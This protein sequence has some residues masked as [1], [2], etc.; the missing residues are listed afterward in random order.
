MKRLLRSSSPS[1]PLR[2]TLE[3]PGD[4]SMSHRAL[5][6]SALSRGLSQVTNLNTGQDCVATA[7][8]LTELG[9]RCTIHETNAEVEVEGCGVG[10]FHEADGV[11][12]AGNSGTTL[13]ILLGVCAGID[14]W[15][16]LTGDAS[17]RTRPMLRV[18]APLRQMGARIDGR[19]HGDRAPLA[20]RGGSLSGVDLE[21]PVASAQLKTA[22]LFAGLAA[23]GRTSVTV[24]GPSRDHTERMLAAA[25]ARL[26]AS[27]GKVVLDP[28]VGPE[29]ARWDVPGD[30]SSAAFLLAAAAL[31]PGSDLTIENVGL[32]PTR[33]GALEVMRRMGAAIEVQVTGERGGEPVGWVRARASYLTASDIEGEEIPS[34]IDELP[35]LAVLAANAE[36]RTVIR[37]AAELRVKESDRI[38]V[39]TEGLRILGVDCEATPDG[40]VIDGP[41]HLA[42]GTVDSR[43]DHRTAMSFAVA[44]LGAAGSVKV[45]GWGCVNT[46]FP[47]FLDL[48]GRAQGGHE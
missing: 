23:E 3:V 40:M 36:G 34:L 14:G 25:G 43:G 31:V 9:A 2:G 10:G 17:L 15:S 35:L 41:A 5:M 19:A 6:I 45:E 20:V 8:L 7:R 46:S 32:N 13:R 1:S 4:K 11:L 30:I 44:G 18:V 28:A 12:D 33:S 42:G 38:A 39:M 29:P 47:E 48:L 37:D 26:S 16:V 24:P 21:L 27:K 22:V